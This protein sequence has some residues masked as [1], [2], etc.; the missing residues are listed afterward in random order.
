[1]AIE[2]DD[3]VVGSGSAG[4]AVAARLSEDAARRVLLLEAGPH[5]ASMEEIPSDIRNGSVMSLTGHDWGYY[6]EIADGMGDDP[7]RTIRLPRGKLTGG[8]SAVGA[9]IFLRGTPDDFDEW[10]ALGNDEW[11][12][13]E[14]LPYYRK[15]EDDLDFANELHGRGGPVPV[16]R[17]RPDELT[18]TQRTFRDVSVA[19]GWKEVED[20]NHPEATGVGPIPSNR[21]EPTTRVSTAMAYLLS[22]QSRPNLT[23]AAGAHV[24]R[25]RIRNGRA[26]GV[27]LAN[28]EEVSAGR[29]ILSAGAIGTPSILLR[30]GIG[31]AGDLK[32]LGI[33][34]ILDRP[35][36]GA[37]LSDHP[38]TGV[39][40]VPKPG[41]WQRSDPFV[42]VMTR[43]GSPVTGLTNDLQYFMVGHFDLTL[44]PDLLALSGTDVILGVCVGHQ[45]PNA[46]GRMTLTSA[47]P[48][49]APHIDLDFLSDEQDYDVLVDGVRRCWEMAWCSPLRDFGEQPVVLNEDAMAIEDMVRIYIKVSL[50]S[51]YHPVGTARMGRADDENAVVD[52]QCRVHGVDGLWVADTS[53]MPTI[54]RANTNFTAIAIGERVADWLR[55]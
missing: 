44:F 53:V 40:M 55:T 48:H 6:A 7:R 45:K 18:P 17:W 20:H 51:T 22:A 29:V 10:V 43:T 37:N 47:D 2:Y 15:L 52:Q 38:R 32:R 5:F 30:S 36:V 42:Q 54:V 41:T 14:V 16:R 46:R 13:S 19:A 21:R 33:D 12:W 8:S 50:D 25:V 1:M 26:A 31:P 28:G 24:D 4:A 3:V 35:G 27:T 34:P 23:I 39:F 9:T 49:A 11:A